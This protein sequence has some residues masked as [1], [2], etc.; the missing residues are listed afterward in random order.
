MW[1]KSPYLPETCNFIQ[2]KTLAQVFSSEFCEIFK[3]TFFTEQ[4][5]TTASVVTVF[6]LFISNTRNFYSTC[7][8]RDCYVRDYY[9][10]ETAHKCHNVVYYCDCTEVFLRIS[11]NSVENTLLKATCNHMKKETVAQVL[12]CEFREVFKNTFFIEHLLATASVT[13][14]AIAIKH[15]LI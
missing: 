2:K 15:K 7:L 14:K 4:Q 13:G 1:N 8:I 10:L 9:S 6:G 3:N 12:S 11:Q 5:W